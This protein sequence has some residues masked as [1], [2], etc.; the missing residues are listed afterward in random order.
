MCPLK[1]MA[2]IH[3][4]FNQ[5]N[6]II[7]RAGRTTCDIDKTVTIALIKSDNKK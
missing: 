7:C 3:I 4:I 1:V 2:G 5:G 6:R